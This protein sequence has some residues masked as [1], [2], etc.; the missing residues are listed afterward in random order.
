MNQFEP[1]TPEPKQNNR[2]KFIWI[3][4]GGCLVLFMCVGISATLGIAGYYYYQETNATQISDVQITREQLATRRA[5]V[6]ATPIPSKTAVSSDRVV[7]P[8]ATPSHEPT[9]EPTPS[10]ALPVPD[11]IDQRPISEQAQADL[12]TLFDTEYPSN[13]YFEPAMR[14]GKDNSLGSRTIDAPTYQVGDTRTFFNGDQQIEATLTA[15]TEHTYF[16]VE[17]GLD[18]EQTAVSDT[19]ERFET[20]YYPYITS[21][22]GDL[23]TPG[24]DNDPRFSILNTLDS[25]EDELGRFDSTDEYPRSLYSQSNQQE[26]LYMNMSTLE[27][28][29]DLYFGTLVHELQHLIQ[30]Y[31]DPSETRWVNEGLS[32]L[33]E[34]YVGLETAE[35]YDYLE[36]PQTQLNSWN[37]DDDEVYAHYAGS[38]LFMVYLWEQLGDTAVQEYA[39]HPAN[40]MSGVRAILAGYQPD[41]SLEQ[42]VADWAAANYLDDIMAGPRYYY[43][44]LDFHRPAFEAAV[45]EVPFETTTELSQYGV[46]YYDLNDLRGETTIS[47]AGDTLAD[48]TAAPPRSGSRMWFAPAINEMDAYLTGSFDLTELERATLKYAT[49]Y[50]LEEDYDYAYISVSTDNGVTW[51]LLPSDNTTIGEFGPAYNGRSATDPDARNGW[52]KESIS[53]NAYVGQ[54]VLIRFDVL[55][56]SDIV[57]SGFAIDDIA[58]PELGYETDVETA[59]NDW[60]ATGFA[61]VGWQLPQQWRVQLIEE[62]PNP[63]VTNIPLDSLNQAQFTVEIGKGGG[64]LVITPLT[65]FIRETADYW[66]QIE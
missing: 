65:P 5:E 43:E 55:T 16:W 4:L 64:V 31:V 27:L 14:L 29:S 46:H 15:V 2:N 53:L 17:N 56:D 13:D 1:L 6:S 40:G 35:T 57:G 21:L 36:A 45:E 48:L 22:F 62:G 42:F 59:A 30:W 41:I 34:I 39:R 25:A 19:A 28:G 60:Q 9:G 26:M 8:T 18:L 50:D 52:I 66:L 20:D 7:D 51:D 58:I 49:W 32:Q 3:A 38:Y 24:I 63:T 10:L 47:F 11:S 54:Q 37:N 61:P 33:A 44:T 12:S 23:W